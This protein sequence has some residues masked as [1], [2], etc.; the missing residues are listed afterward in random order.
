MAATREARN[1]SLHVADPNQKAS[2]RA[3]G[4][5]ARLS[6]GPGDGRARSTVQWVRA[7]TKPSPVRGLDNRGAHRRLQ[8]Q[9]VTQLNIETLIRTVTNTCSHM[10]ETITTAEQRRVLDQALETREGRRHKRGREPLDALT[11][12]GHH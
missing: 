8:R 9:H 6:A 4:R 2:W 10:P 3:M 7:R 1:H 5:M 12:A 11:T